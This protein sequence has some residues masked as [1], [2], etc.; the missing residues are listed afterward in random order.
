MVLN[1]YS[2][3]SFFLDPKYYIILKLIY[4]NNDELDIEKKTYTIVQV[5]LL[6]I[7]SVDEIASFYD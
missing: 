7:L 3:R 2:L 5:F 1:K 4:T 6:E